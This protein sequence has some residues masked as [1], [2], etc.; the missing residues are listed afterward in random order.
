M[1]PPPPPSEFQ[2]SAPIEFLPLAVDTVGGGED[3]VRGDE[4]PPTEVGPGEEAVGL[5]LEGDLPRPLV[6]VRLGPAHDPDVAGI[7]V[8]SGT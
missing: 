2:S 5:G 8:A 7:Q 3:V 4:G 6:L 1:T